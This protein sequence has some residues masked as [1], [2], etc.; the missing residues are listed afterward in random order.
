[1]YLNL[2]DA[3]LKEKGTSAVI[4]ALIEGKQCLEFFDMSGDESASRYCDV[5]MCWNR[6]KNQPVDN[7]M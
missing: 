5:M 3:G 2:R 1:V 6:V 7:V 4:K